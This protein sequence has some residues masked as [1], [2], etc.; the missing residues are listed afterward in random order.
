MRVK[1]ASFW[2]ILFSSNYL[3][4]GL[5]ATLTFLLGVRFSVQNYSDHMTLVMLKNYNVHKT[6]TQIVRPA[7]RYFQ[8]AMQEL[9]PP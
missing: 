6:V 2:E 7:E 4:I 1:K 8:D 9:L 3:L 5:L